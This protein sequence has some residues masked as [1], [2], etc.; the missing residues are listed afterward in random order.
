MIRRRL[1]SAPLALAALALFGT[2]IGKV[3]AEPV[4]ITFLHTNDV[5]EI[6]PKGGQGGLAELKTLLDQE[7]AQNPNVII[8]F[9]GDLISPSVMSGLTK[10]KQMIELYNALGTQV[11]VPGNHEFDFGPE[12][13]K[14]RIA[15]SEFPWLGTNVLGADGAPALGMKDLEIIDVGGYKVGFF[16]VLTE[17]TT[18]L[19]S[20]GPD[21][22]FA[23][24]VETAT[25]A[26][27]KL[28]EQGADLVVA[29]THLSLA[30]DRA[31]LREVDDVDLVLG[32][33]DHDPITF[34]EG[35]KLVVKAGYD[36]HYLAAV[37]VHV[38]RV[39]RGEQEVVTW[40]P[41]WR[42]LS[43]AGVTPEPGVQAI[44]A[45]WESELDA[46]LN[47][48]IGTTAVE[49]DATRETVRT[50]ESNVGNLITD[51]IREAVGAD[52]A[53]IGGGGIRGDKRY[54]PGT[55]L[56]RKDVLTELPFG[57]VTVLVELSGADLRAALENGVSQ[58]ADK[59]GRFPQVSGLTFTYDMARPAGDRV[60]KVEVGG[61]P[62]D[63]AKTYKVATND[64]MLGGGDGYTSLENGKVLIDASG[65]KLMA[66]QVIDYIAAKGE[67]AP[68]VEGRITRLN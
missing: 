36:A 13:A 39:K 11:A 67:V 25:A 46:E 21:V 2:A 60:T 8:T 43:T 5:Y 37:D 12:V 49:L 33:H 1:L 6:A 29:L 45:R 34:Y 23:P 51:A 54:E 44:V 22:T 10:G 65:G 66:S 19:S 40:R 48:E 64:Y 20:P 35:G 58:V 4:T 55:T 56:T 14:E 24:V 50:A 28:K 53:L 18:A 30:D 47:V 62:L 59:A 31:L 61:A 63:D 7:R 42:Y 32:G 52:V 68:E 9:G 16:G 57:N 27:A 38:D 17:E 26:A 41:S 15:E 3:A